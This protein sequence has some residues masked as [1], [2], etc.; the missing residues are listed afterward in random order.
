[1]SK[2]HHPIWPFPP[3]S[4]THLPEFLRKKIWSLGETG[5]WLSVRGAFVN[6][7]VSVNVGENNKPGQREHIP[8][9]KKSEWK[10]KWQC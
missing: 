7:D 1:M 5:T 6:W 10:Q 8:K 2:K 4:R 9:S 3:R